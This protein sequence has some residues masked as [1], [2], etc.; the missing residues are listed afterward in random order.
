MTMTSRLG[1]TGACQ[2]VWCTTLYEGVSW[3]QNPAMQKKRACLSNSMNTRKLV[4]E[5]HT[6]NR[7]ERLSSYH[8]I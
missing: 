5:S 7:V 1:A 8:R 6:V 3:I 4:D 2:N